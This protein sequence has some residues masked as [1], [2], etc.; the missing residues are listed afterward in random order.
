MRWGGPAAS[1][2]ALSPGSTRCAAEE[3]HGA[4]GAEQWCPPPTPCRGMC[5]T[6]DPTQA[7]FHQENRT[8]R[9]GGRVGRDEVLPV[10]CPRAVAVVGAM[11]GLHALRFGVTEGFGDPLGCCSSLARERGQCCSGHLAGSTASEHTSRAPSGGEPAAVVHGK[12]GQVPRGLHRASGGGQ[13]AGANPEEPLCGQGCSWAALPLW[14]GQRCR[15]ALS[16]QHDARGRAAANRQKAQTGCAGGAAG[17]TDRQTDKTP[18]PLG[19]AGSHRSGFLW[20]I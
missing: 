5:N 17:G 1:R 4:G 20:L 7:F 13:K 10:G 6:H 18:G 15:G 14:G 2:G 8:G 11:G 19:A 16:A 12:G 9:D 3:G